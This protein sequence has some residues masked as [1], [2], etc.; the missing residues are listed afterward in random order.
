MNTNVL[1][2]PQNYEKWPSAKVHTLNRTYN[3]FTYMY[4]NLNTN[5]IL[6]REGE[7]S[8]EPRLNRMDYDSFGR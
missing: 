5:L 3:F 2:I 7:Y 8:Q 6:D 4:T 1:T